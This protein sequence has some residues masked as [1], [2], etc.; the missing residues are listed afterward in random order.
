MK[1]AHFRT[2]EDIMYQC[3]YFKESNED[4]IQRL[5]DLFRISDTYERRISKDGILF[6]KQI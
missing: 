1:K 5:Y 2:V 3:N 4:K 6:V